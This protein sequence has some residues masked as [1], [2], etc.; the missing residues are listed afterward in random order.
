M[1][2]RR[3]T[4]AALG[5]A[6]LLTGGGTRAAHAL[7]FQ[8]NAAAGTPQQVIDGFTAAGQRWSA[9]FSD[10]ITLR[11]DIDFRSLGTNSLGET[12][13]YYEDL[14]WINVRSKMVADAKSTDDALAVAQLP[15]VAGIPVLIN[16]TSNSPLG[17][18]SATP[19]LDNDGDANNTMLRM[20]LANQRALGLVAVRN[21]DAAVVF[22]QDFQWD[23]DPLD[24]IARNRYDFVGIAT[25]ELG[26]AM[27]VLS[28]VDTLDAATAVLPD[29][30]FA[31][32]TPMDLFR[33]SDL[34]RLS[35]AI[36]FT[37]DARAKY[38][39][40]GDGTQV[41][42]S[43]GVNHGDGSQASHW[44][45]NA[46]AGIF[47]P[48]FA[49]SELLT[50]SPND[51]RL[52]D[53][54]GYDRASSWSWARPA[55]GEWGRALNWASASNL[56]E[57]TIGARFDAEGAYTVT[58][59]D[60]RSA[61]AVDVV[62]G[63]VTLHSGVGGQLA[64]AEDV[65][66][67]PTAGAVA[68][69]T[70][71]GNRV[72]ARSA[73]VGGNALAAGGAGTF[74]LAAGASFE[75]GETVHVWQNGAVALAGAARFVAGSVVNNGVFDSGSD[76]TIRER[77]TNNGGV[78]TLGGNHAW[79]ASSSLVVNGGAVNLETDL[80][81]SGARNVA[82]SV[83]GGN[84]SVN[85]SQRLR[86]LTMT[87]GVATLRRGRDT[88]LVTDSLSLSAAATLDLADNG[89][90][91]SADEASRDAVLA[92]VTEWVRNARDSA[93]GRWKG[94]GITSSAAAENPLTG[95]AVTLNPGLT[96]FEGYAVSPD[97]ILVKHTWTGDITLDERVNSDDY[98]RIDS[99][100]LA[101]AKGFRNGDLNYDGRINSD[102][103]FLIDSSFL[104][105]GVT[106]SSP[107][108]AMASVSIPEPGIMLIWALTVVAA[109]ARVRRPL[110]KVS[111]FS[112][113]E[114]CRVC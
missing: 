7:D 89:M 54:I 113:G 93:A 39:S 56:N 73:Y 49:D 29:H 16:R 107:V 51:R 83:N 55:G 3:N 59:A 62:T 61:R 5:L 82:V 79:S 26:H 76:M 106:L 108:S 18:G 36:D 70:L 91:I 43:T 44:K 96:S 75:A 63:H 35:A 100:F 37:A 103:Y 53:V 85:H 31:A 17:A 99:G 112:C 68:R 47:D 88:I 109:H 77:F 45:D 84:L 94:T 2:S 11:I 23:F 46:D 10:Q 22:N 66:V 32:V 30:A 111:T 4:T 114:F 9:I 92:R 52:L 102:D 40:I 101:G 72:V 42:L 78:A 110:K 20:S 105:Q 21:Q 80:G 57:S 81:P 13:N 24:G 28:G 6:F 15:S 38:F 14:S 33:F 69:L 86:D 104:G 64:L 34:S 50:V 98:F 97:D 41:G 27:G 25:H 12:T 74:E 48:S 1:P 8:F 67:A 19:Y 90:V 71:T 58:V 60:A 95:L 65:T 87:A